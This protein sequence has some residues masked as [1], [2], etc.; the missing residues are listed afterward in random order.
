MTTEGLQERIKEI[1]QL[2]TDSPRMKKELT[3]IIRRAI[4]WAKKNVVKDAR[5][6][7]D[8]DPRSAYKAVRYSVYKQILQIFGGQINILSPRHRGAPTNY[9]RHRKLDDNPHQRGGNRRQRSLRTMQVES[10]EGKDRAFIL[11]FLNA[12]TSERETR[13]GNRGSL[14]ARNWFATSSTLQMDTAARMVVED[15][16]K[17]LSEEFKLQ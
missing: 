9:V 16:E 4:A 5:G 17:L 13:Y 12:G 6:V 11:R 15:I 2:A 14:P 10:Y 8:N 7:L 3:A 1:R